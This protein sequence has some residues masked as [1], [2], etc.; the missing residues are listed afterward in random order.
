MLCGMKRSRFPTIASALLLI[1]WVLPSSASDELALHIEELGPGLWAALQPEAQRFNDSNSL[2]VAGATSTLV[3]DTQNQPSDTRK[4]ARE[5]RRLTRVPVHYVVLT[6]WHGDH[7]QGAQAYRD[8]FGP[9]VVILGHASLRRDIP[10]RTIPALREQVEKLE[11]VL[12]DAREALARGQGLDGEELDD[13]GRA[14]FAGRIERNRAWADEMTVVEIPI[15]DVAITSETVIDLG[16]REVRLL[17]LPGHTEGDLVVTVPGTGVIAT[18]DLLDRLPFGGH[19]DLESGIAS[20]DTLDAMDWKVAV[21]GH[22]SEVLRGREHLVR[23]RELWGFLRER[24]R[25]GR[26][27]GE[28]LETAHAALLADPAYAMLR[29]QLAGSDEHVGRTFDRFVPATF[30][31]CWETCG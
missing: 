12:A 14:A 24:V 16:S 9:E 18:G 2:I 10:E 5:I 28:D 17:P 3:V 31:R 25:G 1:A 26:A 22:G 30:D 8:E 23:V 21:P 19:G 6:H 15:P 29:R 13:P 4:L 20:L 7:T 27:A 11:A